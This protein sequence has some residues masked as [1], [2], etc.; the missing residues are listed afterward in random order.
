M[1]KIFS[2][3]LLAIF[4][5][6]SAY[7]EK[8]SVPNIVTENGIVI[9]SDGEISRLKRQA[10]KVLSLTV[11]YEFNNIYVLS[12]SASSQ[13]K[14]MVYSIVDLSFKVMLP[15]VVKVAVPLSKDADYLVA[16][17]LRKGVSEYSVSEALEDGEKLSVIETRLRKNPRIIRARRVEPE[18]ISPRESVSDTLGQCFNVESEAFEVESFSSIKVNSMLELAGVFP[19]VGDG[20]WISAGGCW[21]DSVTWFYNKPQWLWQKKKLNVWRVTNG[22]RVEVSGPTPPGPKPYFETLGNNG[23]AVI[24]VTNILPDPPLI[25]AYDFVDRIA[26]SIPLRGKLTFGA[27]TMFPVGVSQDRSSIYFVAG[28]YS[29]ENQEEKT[30]QMFCLRKSAGVWALNQINISAAL[31]AFRKY[32]GIDVDKKIAD[33][34]LFQIQGV[35]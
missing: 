14:M 7:A 31:D 24:A 17:G 21:S 27:Q 10:G 5:A 8:C 23:E 1:N 15:G 34:E 6:L 25:V 28:S 29:R 20:S 18:N 26:F 11:D 19:K 12:D 22:A 4:T 2:C 30:T 3:F 35:F 33:E 16:Q 32:S 13:T 9:Q